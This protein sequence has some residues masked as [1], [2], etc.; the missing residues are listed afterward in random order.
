M[1]PGA[2]MITFFA[3]PFRCAPAFA[4]LVN[5][6]V[7]SSTHVD[8]ELAP[9]QFGRIA[10]GEHPDA[11]AVDDHGVA[12]DVAPRRKLPCAVS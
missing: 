1:P 3:P 11:V 6:P 12:V 5:R 9:G 8:A 10:L 7:H 4:L 2:E